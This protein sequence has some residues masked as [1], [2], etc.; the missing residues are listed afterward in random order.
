MLSGPWTQQTCGT[1]SGQCGSDSP[2]GLLLGDGGPPPPGINNP[3]FKPGPQTC[4]QIHAAAESRGGGSCASDGGRREKEETLFPH[5][6]ASPLQ[7]CDAPQGSAAPTLPQVP[8]SQ[9]SS[10]GNF[11]PQNRCKDTGLQKSTCCAAPKGCTTTGMGLKHKRGTTGG[12]VSG[13]L[14]GVQTTSSTV[15]GAKRS[16]VLAESLSHPL[17]I[18]THQ[19]SLC[20][21]KSTA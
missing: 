9:L 6:T 2:A 13:P 7:N 17:L 1:I 16:P 10:A 11:S 21:C 5:N 8:P 19:G 20:T 18:P 15:K 4:C 14:S 3:H 12:C